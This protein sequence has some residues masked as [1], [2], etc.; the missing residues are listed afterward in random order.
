[1]PAVKDLRLWRAGSPVLGGK[2][3]YE[4]HKVVHGA[5]DRAP[6]ASAWSHLD[7]RWLCGEDGILWP[8][9]LCCPEHL[10]ASLE[11]KTNPFFRRKYL[12]LQ[13]GVPASADV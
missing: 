6:S 3:L 10:N 7:M 11:K 1:M 12:F 5:A 4:L 9:P 13:A 2:D 8:R